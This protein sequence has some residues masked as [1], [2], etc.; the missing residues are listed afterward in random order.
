MKSK[1]QLDQTKHIDVKIRKIVS[2]VNVHSSPFPETRDAR[3]VCNHHAWVLLNVA[4]TAISVLSI[5]LASETSKRYTYFLL[6]CIV[7]AKRISFGSVFIRCTGC[8]GVK[9]IGECTSFSVSETPAVIVKR[10][11]L[12]SASLHYGHN[13]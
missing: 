13:V 4:A 12:S 11:V 10:H 5:L 3:L 1:K 8:R 6:Q 2:H 9:S 7:Y